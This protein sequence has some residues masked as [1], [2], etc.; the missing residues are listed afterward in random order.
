M[1]STVILGYATIIIFMG[2]L[3]AKKISALVGLIVVPAAVALVG[4]MGG[5]VGEYAMKGIKGVSSTGAL[6]I[7]AVLY[8]CIMIAAGMFDPLV[9]K[10]VRFIKGDPVKLMVGTGLLALGTSLDGD[11][12]TTY[13]I[14]CSALVPI[15]RK[16][17]IN[18]LNL[19]VI[20]LMAN[21]IPNILPWGGPT[22]RLLAATGLDVSDVMAPWYPTLVVGGIYVLL[23]SYIMGI[24]ERKRRGPVSMT[25]EETEELI[26][27]ATA[28]NAEFK[29][30]KYRTF[31]WILSIFVIASIVIDIY[32]P[33]VMF[34]IASAIA[35]LVNFSLKEQKELLEEVGGDI[36]PVA[37]LVFAAGVF[38]GILSESG[39]A[40]AIAQ[41][42]IDMIPESMAA[43]FP[44][45][46]SFL[47]VPLLF[48]SSNDAFYFGIVPVFVETAASYGY[49][50]LE[51]GLAS[52]VGQAFR[53]LSPT[54][55][56]IYV[57]IQMTGVNMVEWQITTAKWAIGLFV[58]YIVMLY[59]V[60]G[61]IPL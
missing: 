12:V 17:G 60:L 18:T 16:M 20:T 57:L 39:M 14:V 7:F 13:I 28:R 56:S 8:F 25:A 47:S 35:L 27:E 58:I 41:N 46:I 15:Y 11:S 2:L 32:P 3:M 22:A 24:Q 61:A 33:V 38:M 10:I 34:A 43:H 9:E 30:P 19:A 59:I 52:L 4:G 21:S 23:V 29:K 1:I 55:A 6:M 42:L 53:L 50:T 5:E 36:L 31:N 51:I 37:S 44:I 40:A 45:I 49:T 48:V 54:V 26:R